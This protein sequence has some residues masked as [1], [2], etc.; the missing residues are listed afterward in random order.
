[1]KKKIMASLLVGSAV[2]GASLAP[3]SAQAVTTGNTPVQVEFGGGVLPE[4]ELDGP[5]VDPDPSTKNTDF[6]IVAIPINFNFPLMKIGEDLS[7]I[8]EASPGYRSISIG[9]LRGTK[10]GWHVT[11][12]IAEMSNGTEKLSGEF[13]FNFTPYYAEYVS[14]TTVGYYR[15]TATLNGV[16]IAD[17]PTAP[18]FSGTSMKIGGGATLLINASVGKGQGIWLGRFGR[19][20]PTLNVTTPYQQLKKGAYTGNITWNLVAGPSI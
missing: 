13:N 12:E 3:L 8:K 14:N 6:D 10:E 15:P 4:H 19:A 11:G 5:D 2:V 17:D 9:D 7:A 20:V 1:M 16:N 18:S